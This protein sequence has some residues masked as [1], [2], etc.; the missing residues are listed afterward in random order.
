MEIKA[1]MKIS[2]MNNLR[3]S[4][5]TRKYGVVG[6]LLFR[7]EDQFLVTCYHC[8]W[9]DGLSWDSFNNEQ[10]I[11]KTKVGIFDGDWYQLI[12]HIEYAVRDEFADLAL[13]KIDKEQN[14]EIIEQNL[15]NCLNHA[16]PPERDYSDT[17]LNIRGV[18]GRCKF[19]IFSGYQNRVK[20]EYEQEEHSFS[21]LITISQNGIF[22]D[23]PFAV[24]GESG[25]FI[26]CGTDEIIGILLGADEENKTFFALPYQAIK[27][28]INQWL[29]QD[30]IS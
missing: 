24:K 5:E 1:G 12:G 20:F 16:K 6:G 9:C 19:G 27:N 30:I 3:T 18:N 23:E 25:S 8:V 10:N 13:I 29:N 28:T 2:N 15:L 14:V 4:T 11:E 17:I 21:E 26:K 22:F 7:G